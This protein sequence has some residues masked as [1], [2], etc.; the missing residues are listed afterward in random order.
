[1]EVTISACRAPTDLHGSHSN[2]RGQ[3]SVRPSP[4][5]RIRRRRSPRYGRT[6]SLSPVTGPPRGNTRRSTALD[7]YADDVDISSQV[8]CATYAG[9]RG[10][11]PSARWSR[12][13]NEPASHCGCGPRLHDGRSN[14]SKYVMKCGAQRRTIGAVRRADPQGRWVGRAITERRPSTM[15]EE[16]YRQFREAPPRSDEGRRR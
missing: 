16:W 12:G 13:V 8:R 7:E 4:L 1:M 5:R 3:H 15:A 10:R 9:S 2:A 14:H 6:R 11:R